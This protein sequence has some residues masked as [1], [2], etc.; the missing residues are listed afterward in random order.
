MT[1]IKQKEVNTLFVIL[2]KTTHYDDNL[3]CTFDKYTPIAICDTLYHLDQTVMKF[4]D[5]YLYNKVYIAEVPV[6]ELWNQRLEAYIIM[7]EV[8]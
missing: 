2:Y 4:R 5:Q 3:S 1:T 7:E 6:N 8:L